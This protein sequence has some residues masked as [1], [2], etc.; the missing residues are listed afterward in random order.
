MSVH[1]PAQSYMIALLNFKIGDDGRHPH[2][3]ITLIGRMRSRVVRKMRTLKWWRANL[4]GSRNQMTGNV[5]DTSDEPL[6]C[7][8]VWKGE[9][10]GEGEEGG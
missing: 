6:N 3:A 1:V 9:G 8:W 4:T 5:F 2:R 7:L 10:G